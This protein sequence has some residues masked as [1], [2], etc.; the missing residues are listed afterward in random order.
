MTQQLADLT[1][2]GAVAQHL[3]GQSMTELMGACGRGI[4]A[5]ALECM[6]NDGSHAAGPTKP[7]MGALAR[8]NTR[9]LVLSGLPWR[10]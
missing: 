5:G 3:R 7:R 1:E 8:K 4:D 6:P 10:R 9:R 2:R